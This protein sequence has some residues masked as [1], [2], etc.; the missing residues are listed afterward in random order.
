MSLLKC[1]LMLVDTT[2]NTYCTITANKMVLLRIYF[3]SRQDCH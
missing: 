3:E 2:F 1:V